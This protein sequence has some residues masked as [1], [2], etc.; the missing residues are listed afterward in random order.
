MGIIHFLGRAAQRGGPS[1]FGVV[2]VREDVDVGGV[3]QE[4]AQSGNIPR[5]DAVPGC[6]AAGCDDSVLSCAAGCCDSSMGLDIS[7]RISE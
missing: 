6:A 4:G 7:F 5:H 2:P 1:S 3:A